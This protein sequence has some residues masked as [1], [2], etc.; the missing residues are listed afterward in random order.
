MKLSKAQQVVMDMAIE[1]IT[2]ARTHDFRHWIAKAHSYPLEKD[3][4]S[5]PN[6]YLTNEIVSEYVDRFI[7]EDDEIHNGFFRRSYEDEKSG[8]T[9][10]TSNSRTIKALEQLGLIE[11]ISDGRSGIDEIKVLNF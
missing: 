10:V 4:D 2:Y 8:I 5:L 6:P 1:K 11:I 7:R 9:L 3:W